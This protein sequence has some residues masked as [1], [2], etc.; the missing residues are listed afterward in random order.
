MCVCGKFELSQ[1]L[2]KLENTKLNFLCSSGFHYFCSKLKLVG[3]VINCSAW[4]RECSEE[5]LLEPFNIQKGVMRQTFTEVCSDSRKGSG[6][7]MKE[8]RFKS[9]KWKKSF[10]M[11]IGRNRSSLPKEAL[12]VPTLDVSKVR[13]KVTW[14]NLG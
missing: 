12:D 3:I 8:G 6:F 7:K 2:K 9:D 11:R 1:G 5:T 14:S 13:F 4:R 10:A